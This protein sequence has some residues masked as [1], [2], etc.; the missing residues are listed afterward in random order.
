MCLPYMDM[1]A[2]LF[3]GPE[4]LKQIVNIFSTKLLVQSGENCSSGFRE[5]LYLK[6]FTILIIHFKFYILV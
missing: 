2:F 6:R 4:P 3:Y 5:D 1:A